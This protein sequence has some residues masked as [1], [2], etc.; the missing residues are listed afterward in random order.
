MTFDGTHDQPA[1][2]DRLAGAAAAVGAGSLAFL[3]LLGVVESFAAGEGHLPEVWPLMGAAAVAGA[4]VI[5]GTVGLALAAGLDRLVARRS[6][7]ELA[8]AYAFAGLLVGSA[9]GVVL[10]GVR[11]A[12]VVFPIAGALAGVAGGLVSHRGAGRLRVI[13]FICVGL[14]LALALPVAVQLAAPFIVALAVIVVLGAVLATTRQRSG[15]EG[16]RTS[17]PG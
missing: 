9:V 10:A 8:A 6:T 1:P 12:P 17:A 11:G 2:R 14:L 5:V 16:H 3:V 13:A 4:A 15:P 7:W